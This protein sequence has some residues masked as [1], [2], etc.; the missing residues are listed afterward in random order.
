MGMVAGCY[1]PVTFFLALLAAF[2]AS[3]R[4][5]WLGGR[6]GVIEIFFENSLIE[7]PGLGMLGAG[8]VCS[9]PIISP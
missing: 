4:F 3:G 2:A 5:T 7:E 6:F 8:V 1:Q 9:S